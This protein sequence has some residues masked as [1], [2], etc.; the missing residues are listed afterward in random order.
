MARNVLMETAAVVSQE[1][2]RE[3]NGTAGKRAM[4]VRNKLGSSQEPKKAKG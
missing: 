1:A 2:G 3:A 4:R